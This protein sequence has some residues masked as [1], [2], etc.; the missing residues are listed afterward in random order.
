MSNKV[1]VF[2]SFNLD[3]VAGMARFPQPGDR[4]IEIVPKTFE[5]GRQ[6]LPD[7]AQ[8]VAGS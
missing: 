1:C 8:H 3:I 6:R 7:L 4:R 5:L 2:G